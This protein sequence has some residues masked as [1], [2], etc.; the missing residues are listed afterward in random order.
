MKEWVV[1]DGMWVRIGVRGQHAAVR[2]KE[3]QFLGVE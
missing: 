1:S 2:W 3:V